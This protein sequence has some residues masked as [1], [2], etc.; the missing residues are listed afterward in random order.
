MKKRRSH[1]KTYCQQNTESTAAVTRSLKGV[2]TR[3]FERQKGREEM[4]QDGKSCYFESKNLYRAIPMTERAV[5]LKLACK[6]SQCTQNQI[7]TQ[8]HSKKN[9][10]GFCDVL[11][12]GLVLLKRNDYASTI[13]GAFNFDVTV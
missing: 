4:S 8:K 11:A 2:S 1:R 12:P 9:L 10:D 5:Q 6:C 3:P 7:H 13:R